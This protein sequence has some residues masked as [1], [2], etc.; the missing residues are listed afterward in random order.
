[1]ERSTEEFKEVPGRITNSIVSEIFLAGTK[2]DAEKKRVDEE[3]I[4]QRQADIQ[5]SRNERERS[6]QQR[7]ELAEAKKRIKIEEK[8]REI[9]EARLAKATQM[10]R[11]RAVAQTVT[12]ENEKKL[13]NDMKL[14]ANRVVTGE[15][16]KKDFMIEL[17]QMGQ[18]E[19]S[20][21]ERIV[22][23]RKR[24]IA[25]SY[26]MK[27]IQNEAILAAIEGAAAGLVPGFALALWAV[28]EDQSYFATDE[29]TLIKIPS[30]C[31]LLTSILV[32]RLSIPFGSIEDLDSFDSE[33]AKS[34]R[35]TFSAGPKS[36][37]SAFSFAS[38][39]D[40]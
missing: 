3:Y 10:T 18:K 12:Y 5:A 23:Q 2:V 26:V 22:L 33:F 20:I 11:E 28:A 6:A 24:E 30:I 15:V 9:V 4:S 1:M 8:K 31:A 19:V 38:N 17:R 25:L 7:L 29:E 21:L 13:L 32:Y 35:S 14:L 39:E 34:I 37:I 36:V 16:S 27:E 40:E